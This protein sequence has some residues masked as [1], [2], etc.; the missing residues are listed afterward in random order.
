M[1]A[2][3]PNCPNTTDV[4]PAFWAGDPNRPAHGYA[5]CNR[6]E[7]VVQETRAG[8]RKHADRLAPT[9]GRA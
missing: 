3:R 1:T 4:R 9:G 7:A 5:K 2:R 8:I 6:C